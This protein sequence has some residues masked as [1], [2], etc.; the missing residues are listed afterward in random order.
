MSVR[1]RLPKHEAPELEEPAG[2]DDIIPKAVG[3]RYLP[4]SL[5]HTRAHGER[6]DFE[7]EGSLGGDTLDQNT[8]QSRAQRILR[9]ASTRNKEG[10][11]ASV[12]REGRACAGRATHQRS[13]SA[14]KAVVD[15]TSRAPVHG[16]LVAR[17][18][19]ATTQ[20]SLPAGDRPLEWP[21]EDAYRPTL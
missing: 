20:R 10:G 16:G 5:G 15:S 13:A 21:R 12:Q 17:R 14:S 19:A 11:A 6:L 3:E 9:A 4:Q 1:T 7:S 2:G 18:C 8:E